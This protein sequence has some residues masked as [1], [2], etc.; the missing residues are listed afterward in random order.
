MRLGGYAHARRDTRYGTL[1]WYRKQ[2]LFFKGDTAY[3][4]LTRSNTG[5]SLDPFVEKRRLAGSGTMET[6]LPPHS[7]LLL[8]CARFRWYLS[9]RSPNYAISHSR[10]GVLHAFVTKDGALVAAPP[11][12]WAVASRLAGTGCNPKTCQGFCVYWHGRRL[13]AVLV[14]TRTQSVPQPRRCRAYADG[15]GLRSIAAGLIIG[16]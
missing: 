4:E 3:S 8:C 10:R 15:R 14:R 7:W 5:L 6:P 16:L 13:R 1:A 11:P 9:A 12:V 2:L